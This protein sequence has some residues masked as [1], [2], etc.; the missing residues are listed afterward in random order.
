MP[1]TR[2]AYEAIATDALARFKRLDGH[3]V[4]FV[5]GV[6][7]HGLKMK[8]TAAKLGVAPL[9]LAEENT[10][11]FK[12]MLAGLNIAYDDFIS[13][14]EPRHFDS[15]S[16][17]WRRMEKA[18][19]IYL[20]GYSGWYSVRDEAFYA[21]NETVLGA[22]GVRLGPQ[23]TPV[24]WTEEQTYFFRLSKYEKKLLKLYEEKPDFLLP[25]E[26]RNEIV[27]F[28]KGG[29]QDLSISRT[30][31]DWG[32]PVPGAPGHIIYVWVD[33]LTNYITAA[34]FPKIRSKVWK[35]RWPAQLHVIGKDITRFHAVY[36]PAFLMSAKIPL[37]ER[38]FSHGF[39]YNKGEKM[40]KSVG[41]VVAPLDMAAAYG[42]DPV[43]YFFLREVPFG[44]DGSFTHEAIVNR[45]NADLAND[46]GNLAQRSLSMI[47]KNCASRIPEPGNFTE[48]D[49]PLLEAALSL[50]PICREA[51]DRQAIHK[52]IEAIW[53]VVAEA[54]RYFA[55]QE[56]W[57]LK[58]TD[59]AR[60]GTVLYVT[61]EVVR[62][63]AI[64]S[65]PYVPASA[66]KFLD[67]LGVPAEE[68][69]FASLERDCALKPG[70]II[71]TPQ[72]VFPR[73]VEDETRAAE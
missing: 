48:A 16:E 12:D 39:L 9:E 21:E 20:A 22:N 40:S 63:V 27:S 2:P 10:R 66:P 44:H 59:P 38:V 36:W 42:A 25:A 67:Q 19:D 11:K 1:R 70:T 60:M 35:E 29:L 4:F 57:S 7:A 72:P 64:L 32:I 15:V 58:K 53:H 13:T 62:R 45:I 47:A 24:E 3:P 71:A 5:T 8:Q 73:Y 69:S 6:D 34:G 17:I 49:A 46:L 14:R 26:R 54:N 31:L 41:N 43:R 61:A 37:P 18:G 51:M 50:L 33:A 56:P 68:R 65:Q 23:G 28:V 30:T 52:S 55:A